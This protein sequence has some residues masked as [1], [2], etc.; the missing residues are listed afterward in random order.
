[1]SS[2]PLRTYGGVS[3]TD[4]QAERRAQLVAAG[5]D[6]L[7][8]DDGVRALTVRGVCRH[9]G[10]AARYFYENFADRDAL[11]AA[12]YDHVVEGIAATTLEAVQQAP[13]DA[14]AKVRAGLARLV[15]AVAEDPRRGRLLFSPSMADS[16][17]A[18]R[19]VAST[20]M[21]VRLLGLQ[22]R[23]FYGVDG[24]T[25]LDILAEMLVGGLAQT[26]TSW[27]DGSLE[28]TEDE[29]VGHCAELFLAVADA[30]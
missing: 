1:M 9:A 21:F 8:S 26:F 30:P 27:L 23:E 17:L 11:A 22:A 18:A 2:A 15:R 4:R 12:V 29:I 7:G 19:R 10:L 14:D 6:L 20:R 5:L 16:T 3:G 13:A 25:R 28:A 24:S